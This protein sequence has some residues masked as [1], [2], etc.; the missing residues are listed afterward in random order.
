[1]AVTGM[2]HACF[3]LLYGLYMFLEETHSISSYSTTGECFMLS[4]HLFN[5]CFTHVLLTL[6]NSKT[7]P[8]YI[9]TSTGKHYQVAWF[10]HATHKHVPCFTVP[11]TCASPTQCPI[12]Y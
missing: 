2:F 11:Y 3:R 5:T 8:Y 9:L 10:N 4:S 7:I 12:S 1:M 6:K